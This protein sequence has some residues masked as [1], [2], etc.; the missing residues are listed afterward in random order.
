MRRTDLS[1]NAKLLYARLVLFVGENDT[2]WPSRETL[3]NELGIHLRSVQRAMSELINADLIERQQGYNGHTNT[4]SII[5]SPII[6]MVGGITGRQLDSSAG[7]IRPT[8]EDKYV[9]LSS[10][11]ED[12]YVPLSRT[13]MS[14]IKEPIKTST[15]KESARGQRSEGKKSKRGSRITEDWQ[16][17]AATRERCVAKT[18][19]PFVDEQIQRFID[20]WIDISGQRGVKLAWDRAFSNWIGNEIKWGRYQ[21][22][23]TGKSS[24]EEGRERRRSGLA[25]AY[26][27]RVAGTGR[28]DTLH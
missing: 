9:P 10:S 3:A 14:H 16:P 2:A 1:A 8:K 5:E 4:Y 18:S 20:Y 27:E 25:D 11:E 21:P 7:Q 13:D 6:N 24:G 23:G 12:K 26:S 28:T 17:D 19:E 22:T 15:K